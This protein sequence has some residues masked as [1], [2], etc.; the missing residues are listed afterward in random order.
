MILAIA[1]ILLFMAAVAVIAELIVS[2]GRAHD[3]NMDAM[4]AN[5]ALRKA[6]QME[7][8]RA[9]AYRRELEYLRGLDGEKRRRA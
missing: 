1:L 4:L 8:A 3:E 2:L 5:H 6:F 9:E 7:A